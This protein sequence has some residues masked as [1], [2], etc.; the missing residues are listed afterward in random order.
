[1]KEVKGGVLS[2]AD[3]DMLKKMIAI[4]LNPD[5]NETFS[6]EEKTKLRHLY[7]RLGRMG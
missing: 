3:V 5:L 1:M 4:T 7:H 6:T 2:T